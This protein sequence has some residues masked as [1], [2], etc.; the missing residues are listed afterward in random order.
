MAGGRETQVTG[1][2]VSKHVSKVDLHAVGTWGREEG[3]V[4]GD[5]GRDG[6]RRGK[7]L[8]G[9]GRGC[10][11]HRDRGSGISLDMRLVKLTLGT[12]SRQRACGDLGS[13]P[14]PAGSSATEML[15]SWQGVT[16]SPLEGTGWQMW[17]FLGSR[18]AEPSYSQ[19]PHAGS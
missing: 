2:G 16:V 10:L 19:V 11:S 13:R 12:I 1:A 8:G 17:G 4:E 5:I 15:S 14:V 6:E 7:R 9:E 18:A 3:L